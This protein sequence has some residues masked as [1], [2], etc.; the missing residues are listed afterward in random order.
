MSQNN[1]TISSFD[2]TDDENN[3]T[4]PASLD[5]DGDDDS[6]VYGY[7]FLIVCPVCLFL[8]FSNPLLIY[9]LISNRK[10]TWVRRTNHLFYLILCDLIVGVILILTIVVRLLRLPKKPYSFCAILSY[11]Q[12]SSQ[13]VSYYHML[14]VCIHRFLKM[15]K[16]DLPYGNDNYRYGV[17][18][19]LI[20]IVVLL[21]FVPP[22]AIP[23]RRDGLPFCRY[24]VIFGPS[25]KIAIVYI[26]TLCGIPCLLTNAIYGAVLCRMKTRL[27]AVRPANPTLNFRNP[28]ENV[29]QNTTEA[30]VSVVIQPSMTEN[31]MG[32]ITNR[33]NRV[34]GYLLAAM[35]TSFLSPSIM[36]S[37]ILGG[38]D[39]IPAWIQA[40]T[41]INN[42]F[43]PFIYSFSI[44]PL[45]EEVKTTLRTMF[46]RFHTVIHRG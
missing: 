18:S 21:A 23:E 42:I 27:N 20:W 37:M 44:A 24:D 4:T 31:R 14:A 3:L 40:L 10:K 17:E 43:S 12:L 38:Y 26:L 7:G 2:W 6:V 36:F 33:V 28:R 13:V 25:D 9:I 41:Y 11:T 22:Y 34:I 29:A 30:V 19:L 35:N 45:R 32:E 1:S 16:I 5:Q 8:V 15:R 46:F 39:N